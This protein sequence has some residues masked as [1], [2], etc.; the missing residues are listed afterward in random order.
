MITLLILMPTGGQIDTPAVH[1]L[2]G[3]TQALPRRGIRFALKTYEWSDLV[4]S[5]NALGVS[6]P[7]ACASRARRS[8]RSSLTSSVVMTSLP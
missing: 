6:R 7:A 3:L 8:G 1:S 5:R 2:L 4:I